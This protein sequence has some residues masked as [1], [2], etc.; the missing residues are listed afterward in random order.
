[1]V[2]PNTVDEVT[3][4]KIPMNERHNVHRL[5][6]EQGRQQSISRGI[7]QGTRSAT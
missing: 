5:L 7:I 2:L 6:A 3:G 1:M 4:Q